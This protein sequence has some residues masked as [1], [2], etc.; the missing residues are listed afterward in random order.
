MDVTRFGARRTQIVPIGIENE[1]V[2]QVGRDVLSYFLRMAAP[3][4]CS[5]LFKL[6]EPLVER[7]QPIDDLS[8]AP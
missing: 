7:G 6:N 2:E 5:L 3:F 8:L 1:V 4:G